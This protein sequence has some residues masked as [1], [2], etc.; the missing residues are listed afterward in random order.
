M[1]PSTQTQ[2]SEKTEAEKTEKTEEV[3]KALTSSQ[4]TEYD[5]LPTKSAKIRYL[6][7][8]GWERGAIAK[9]L[10]I[11]YQHVRNVLVMPVKN[12]KS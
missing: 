1:N 10:G 2:S 11:R 6:N 3:K 5:H 8:Q 12:P 7:A 9:H 4:K